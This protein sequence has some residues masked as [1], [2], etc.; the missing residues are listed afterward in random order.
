MESMGLVTVTDRKENITVTI[1][2][3]IGYELSS[4]TGDYLELTYE[5][6]VDYCKLHNGRLPT[7]AEAYI[8]HLLNETFEAEWTQPF[9]DAYICGGND[10]MEDHYHGV[11]FVD[12]SPNVNYPPPYINY[13]LP[14]RCIPNEPTNPSK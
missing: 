13:K 6:A 7:M 4:E 12:P 3:S 5:Q 2:P 14:F 9:K 8:Y 11:A 10:D 1:D